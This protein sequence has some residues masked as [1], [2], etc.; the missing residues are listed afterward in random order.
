MS[1]VGDLRPGLRL[2]AC[3]LLLVVA[4]GVVATGSRATNASRVITEN[5][6]ATECTPSGCSLRAQLSGLG[7]IVVDLPA[8]RLVL[9][10]QRPLDIRGVVT[11]R[12]ISSAESIIDGFGST[13]LF[14][15]HDGARLTIERVSLLNGGGD[16]LDVGD[17][18][19]VKLL[20]VY[21]GRGAGSPPTGPSS[22]AI[23]YCALGSEVQGQYIGMAEITNAT[24]LEMLTGSPF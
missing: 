2:V 9:S 5:S 8:A 3:A 7:P 21:L 15:L 6:D 12:G 17:R 13:R 11:I 19:G 1:P 23:T 20:D 16:P 4:P 10:Q 14:R 24:A 18:S 22:Q